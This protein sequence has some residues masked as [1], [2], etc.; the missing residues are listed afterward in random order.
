MWTG[1]QIVVYG[2]LILGYL[3]LLFLAIRHRIGRGRAQRLLE[4]ILLLTALWTASLGL[5]ALIPSGVW[6][7]FV[8]QRT[9]QYGLVVS[10]LLTAELAEAFVDRP[11]RRW[12]RLA[13][14]LALLLVA[15]VLDVR[16]FRWPTNTL[17]WLPLRWGPTEVASLLLAGAWAVP[18]AAAW[19]T[20]SR[21]L[22]RAS[23]S[24]HRNRIGYLRLSLLGLTVGD[25]LVLIAGTPGVYVGLAAR[26]LGP[27]LLTF[28]FLRYDL[29]DISRFSRVVLRV[30][31]LVGLTAGL[32]LVLLAVVGLAVGGLANLP[33]SAVVAGAIVLAVLVGAAVDVAL[34]PRVHRYLDRTVLGHG[35]DLQTALRAYSQQISLILDL[36]RLA[37][38]TLDWLQTTLRVERSAF[39]LFT[40]LEAGRTKLNVLRATAS[41]LPPAQV[42]APD[43]RFII[44]FRNIGR[45]LGQYELDM[46]SWFQVM[47][48]DE[49]QWLKDLAVD[50]YVPVLVADKPAALLALGPKADGHPY[51]QEDLETLTILAGQTGTAVD[52]ARLVHDLRTV[53]ADL[54]RLN[55]ELA[56]TNR[57]LKRLDQAKSD[58]VTIASHELRTPLSAIYGY[59]EVLSAMGGDELGDSDVVQQFIGGIAHGAWRLKQVVDALLVMSQL[60][61]GTLKLQFEAVALGDLLADV[62]QAAQPDATGRNQTLMAHGLADLPIIRAD[63]ARLG[64]AFAGLVGNAIKFTPDGREVLVSAQVVPSASGQQEVEVLVVDQ[65][66]GID[67]EQRALI[68]EKFY[69]PEDPLRHS[70][71]DVKFKGAGQGLGL[72]IAKGIVEAHGGRIWVES[73]GRDEDALPGSTFHVL[74][75][76]NGAQARMGDG[77]PLP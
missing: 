72:A 41:P 32:Y 16:P 56:E 25:L 64:Q 10:A 36:E 47:R 67:A 62:V 15:A 59:S 12:A 33:L 68:F 63:G 54:G 46:L 7:H 39:I 43:S 37:D 13:A 35:Y 31:L 42:F 2:S 55:E 48:A 44:H 69:R 3:F 60:E 29:P 71:G 66:I 27:A 75:P 19:W 5:L 26:W 8:W 30:A 23:G 76:M 49:R 38:T 50:L 57:Q 17:A 73:S 58:F 24:K 40:N 21:A 70:T 51:S 34:A 53:Q 11:G 9:A 22:R 18:M 14:V 77:D 20:S 4:A 61:T 45:P 6:W 65:G 28:S 1:P 52:N 74:L